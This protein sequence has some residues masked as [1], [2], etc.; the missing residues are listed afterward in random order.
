MQALDTFSIQ[1]PLILLG[2][3]NVTRQIY[4]HAER[5]TKP[6]EA[7]HYLLS[8]SLTDMKIGIWIP[9]V[10][11]HKDGEVS[12]EQRWAELKQSEAWIIR[13]GDGRDARGWIGA[14]EEGDGVLSDREMDMFRKRRRD[15]VWSVPVVLQ[16]HDIPVSRMHAVM[17][18]LD[19]I[20]GE[21]RQVFHWEKDWKQRDCN[22]RIV[23]NERCQIKICLLPA[24]SGVWE[25]E[26]VAKMLLALAAWE[27]EIVSTESM[28]G[29]LGYPYLSRF[30]EYRGLVRIMEENR[31]SLRMAPAK[32][33]REGYNAEEERWMEEM[34]REAFKELIG[35][36]RHLWDGV[37]EI[38]DGEGAGEVV[39]EMA[40]FEERV[41][42]MNVSFPLAPEEGNSGSTSQ[43]LVEGTYDDEHEH[44]N[45]SHARSTLSRASTPDPAAANPFPGVREIFFQSHKSS[46]DS[47]DI[48]AYTDL[49]IGLTSY[50]SSN[51]YHDLRAR[52]KSFRSTA[53][54][55]DYTPIRSLN[56]L[57]E[58]LDVK[59]G[60]R[61]YYN[62]LLNP[63]K[64]R[65]R[66]AQEEGAVSGG[67]V[68]VDSDE[69]R[70]ETV[71]DELLN[72]LEKHQQQERE[73]VP[74]FLERY[75]QAGG[76][77]ITSKNRLYSLLQA[78]E[79]KLQEQ[80]EK[81]AAQPKDGYN[82]LDSGSSMSHSTPARG[83]LEKQR[84]KREND[85][86]EAKEIG[87]KY[88][89]G[90]RGLVLSPN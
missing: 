83:R 25:E 20:Y 81:N 22:M 37:D 16:R 64:Q 68:D 42:R 7:I 39:K 38:L 90:A 61:M 49:V 50:S 27:R 24:A 44:E 6:L 79:K 18:E 45:T 31:A 41:A 82:V 11:R 28:S 48:A 1:I 56:W 12:E 74:T 57:F 70:K 87:P 19:R 23:C 88:E 75:E 54:N 51:S 86:E 30:L 58:L 9:G 13:H 46:I 63:P 43:D 59:G 21:L 77:N 33:G 73:F 29:I 72:Y 3:K 36:K 55:M 89:V 78:Q 69:E 53:Q 47:D 60:T 76:F 85:E 26:F 35:D 65:A 67:G 66:E 2:T 32:I 5:K 17:Q 52:I 34:Q 4:N 71:F 10:M 40:A 8:N 84:V 14:W 15:E 62:V 80:K